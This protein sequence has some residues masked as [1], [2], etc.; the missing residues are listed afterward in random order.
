MIGEN[1]LDKLQFVVY[2]ST[3]EQENVRCYSCGHLIAKRLK[4]TQGHIQIKC[5][6][7][8]ELNNITFL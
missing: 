2:S 3:I 1:K 7:C 5:N 6:K 8:K 4:L